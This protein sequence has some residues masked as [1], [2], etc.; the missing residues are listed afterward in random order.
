M[1]KSNVFTA[2][3]LI[4]T[5]LMS[6]SL[7]SFHQVAASP[8]GALT[9]RW[10]GVGAYDLVANG[11]GLLG[12]S[13]GD[14]YLD[15]PGSVV[16]RAYLYWA[17]FDGDGG[18]DDILDFAIDDGAATT[19]T[20]DW[21]FGGDE[22]WGTHYHYVYVAN[23]TS[24][25]LPGN[26]KYTVSGV[27]L[28][29]NY[30]AGI[31]AV[32][33]DSSLPLTSVMIYDGLDALHFRF[34]PPQGPDSEVT[35]VDFAPAQDP[36][37]LKF[38]LMAG[39]VQHDNRPNAIWYASGVDPAT[40]P[41]NLVDDLAT[42]NLAGPPYPLGAYN[43]SEWDT[44]TGTIP[45]AA[46]ETWA[47]LQ[48][49]SEDSMATGPDNEGLGTSALFLAAGFVLPLPEPFGTGTPGY[50]KN[51]PDAWPV[52]EITIGGVTYTKE[53]AI[54]IMQTKGTKGDKTYTLFS[55]LVAAK[56]NVL[57]GNPSGCVDDAIADGDAW[58]AMYGPV[59]SDVR[60]KDAAW[61]LGEP[62]KNILDD[63]NN[64]LLCAPPRE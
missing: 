35:C 32:Y 9:P 8:D 58:M 56:L 25:V 5:V 47:C 53:E 18:S 55:Q 43:G 19:L 34:D 20:A 3:M 27:D 54:A 11:I 62:I 57:I 4:L 48:L 45:I 10:T 21:A 22:W 40:K 31:L 12:Q 64:G 15:V 7:I 16:V 23:V 28:V 2:S 46:G 44:Y 6:L 37:D 41:T 33:E 42:P 29:H 14:I 39:G 24:F 36:R 49:E 51:H 59:D 61:D 30:G 13:A 38:T 26:H 60:A 52:E 50:W 17:G 1:R 63:Y